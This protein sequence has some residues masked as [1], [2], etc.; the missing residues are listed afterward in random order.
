MISKYFVLYC[1]AYFIVLHVALHCTLYY[2]YYYHY[3]L[4][5]S[6]SIMSCRLCYVKQCIY[7][8]VKFCKLYSTYFTVLH[9][10]LYILYCTGYYSVHIVLHSAYCVRQCILHYTYCTVLHIVQEG[11]LDLVKEIQL[12]GAVQDLQY[13]PDQK[14]L[15]AADSNRKVYTP[16]KKISYKTLQVIRK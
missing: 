10:V 13:S 11:G 6:Q 1:N 5:Y 9:K 2:Y 14:Y 15:V 3:H 16:L 12:T 8:I 7:H 4:S